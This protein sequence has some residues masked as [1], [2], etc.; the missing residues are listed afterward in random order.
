MALEKTG[1]ELTAEE[2]EQLAA[3]RQKK[4]KQHKEWRDRKKASE[5]LKPRTLKELAEAQTE[6]K[7]LTPEEAERLEVSRSRKKNAYHSLIA[8]AETDPEA[9][10]ELAKKRAYASEATKKS[11][12]KI[13]VYKRQIWNRRE[14]G[15]LFQSLSLPL[16]GNMSN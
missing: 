10:A 8:Q 6:G 15:M 1:A 11:R 7:P 13:D 9:A 5:P 2:S 3:H 14:S 4:A 12:Q 16:S